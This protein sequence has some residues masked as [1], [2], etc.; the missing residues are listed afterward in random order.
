MGEGHPLCSFSAQSVQMGL[1]SN[2]RDNARTLAAL[3]RVLNYPGHRDWFTGGHV[4]WVCQSTPSLGIWLEIPE[5]GPFCP[6]EMM[7][8]RAI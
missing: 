6:S 3:A 1:I 8:A 2:S 4:T 7:G 5:R